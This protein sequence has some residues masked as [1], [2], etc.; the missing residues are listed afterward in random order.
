MHKNEILLSVWNVKKA[1]LNVNIKKNVQLM[2]LML[3]DMDLARKHMSNF[4]LSLEP[5]GGSMLVW[6]MNACST[7]E[8]AILCKARFPMAECQS[9]YR[10]S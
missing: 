10:N 1:F 8:Y 3:C 9:D 6:W 2:M 7:L 4:L 5:I